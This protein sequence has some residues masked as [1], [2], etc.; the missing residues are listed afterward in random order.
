MWNGALGVWEEN[1]QVQAYELQL[2]FLPRQN[3]Y[4]QLFLDCCQ[5]A[6][7]VCLGLFGMIKMT[8]EPV[9]TEEKEKKKKRKKTL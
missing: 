1:K 9:R 7:D 5:V 8:S 2:C 4:N 3:Q 6:P